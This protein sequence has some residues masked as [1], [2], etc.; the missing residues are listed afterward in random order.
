[1]KVAIFLFAFILFLAGFA[2]F[3]YAFMFDG[4]AA[5]SLFTAGVLAASAAF[6]IPFHLLEKFD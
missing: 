4:V 2:A 3:A 6:A 5:I 1:M